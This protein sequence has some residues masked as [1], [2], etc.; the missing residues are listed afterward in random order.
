VDGKEGG[1]GCGE[2]GVGELAAAEHWGEL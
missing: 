2:G 1:G